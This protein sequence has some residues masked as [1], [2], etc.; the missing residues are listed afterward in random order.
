MK[1]Y[2]SSA[3]RQLTC[4]T[5]FL[6]VSLTLFCTAST[7]AQEVREWIDKTGKHKIKAEYKSFENGK[8][9]L[10][11]T[12]NGKRVTIPL[13]KLCDADQAWVNNKTGFTPNPVEPKPVKPAEPVKPKP[14][15]APT[16]KTEA[17]KIAP[18]KVEPKMEPKVEPKMEPK[19]QPKVEPPKPE[20]KTTAPVA[21][22]AKP[23]T[24]VTP[25]PAKPVNVQ[26][27]KPIK[28][29]AGDMAIPQLGPIDANEL[30]ALPAP[31]STKAAAVNSS[32]DVAEI[33]KGIESLE[34]LP[35]QSAN[36]SLI[37][38]LQKHA[39]SE[40]EYTRKS[41][42]RILARLQPKKSLPFVANAL[43]D[44]SHQIRWQALDLVQQNSDPRVIPALVA[45][46]PSSDRDK[47]V[48]ILE[49][50]GTQAEMPVHTMLDHKKKEIR[51]AAVVL[52]RK[53]GT[54]AS[55]DVLTKA[56]SDPNGMIKLEAKKAL[57]DIAARTGQ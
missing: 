24:P 2:S 46:M 19:P 6:F 42:V 49:T 17:P 1:N 50:F 37:N 10:Q 14:A 38:L 13:D 35:V 20:P 21:A 7:D 8:V 56:K 5:T 54:Q 45:R 53:I 55:V 36:R 26:P 41:A 29:N 48:S 22:K 57:K 44:E 18:K 16:P 32:Q 47:V 23:I 40:D 28:F 39:V 30:S 34:N 31:Y 27:A 4:L 43:D 51:R 12:S 3:F 9:I 15:P 52:L 33:R 25:K 11:R